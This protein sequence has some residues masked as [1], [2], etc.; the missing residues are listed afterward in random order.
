MAEKTNPPRQLTDR[1]LATILYA[2]RGTQYDI[3]TG[4][5]ISD[6]LHFVDCDP[7]NAEEIEAL[8]EDLNFGDLTL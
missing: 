1:E 2:L 6:S 4:V 7:L 8:C 3:E 5:D